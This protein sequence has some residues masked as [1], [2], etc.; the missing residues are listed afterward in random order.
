MRNTIKN[1]KEFGS[2]QA[3]NQHEPLHEND[4]CIKESFEEAAV[5]EKLMGILDNLSRIFSQKK[6]KL[7][8]LAIEDIVCLSFIIPIVFYSLCIG[9]KFIIVETVIYQNFWKFLMFWPVWVYFN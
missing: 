5:T 4:G 2:K 1:E 3:I 6:S 7:K 8:P 9:F